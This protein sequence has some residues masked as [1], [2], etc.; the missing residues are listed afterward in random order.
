[1]AKNSLLSG[2]QSEKS[3]PYEPV[4]F[5]SGIG[6][7]GGRLRE[8]TS[9]E[10]LARIEADVFEKGRADGI[11]AGQQVI[12]ETVKRLEAIIGGL[13]DFRNKKIIELMPDIVELAS[14]IAKR[15]IKVSIEKDREIVVSVVRESISKLGGWEEKINVRVNPGDYDI[16]LANLEGLREESRLRDITIEPSASISPGGCYIETQSGEVDARIE[17]QLKEIRDAIATA[18]HS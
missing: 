9:K 10:K 7:Y 17:E 16:I 8:L 13:E 3:K 18:I 11:A 15:I 4:K 5:D 6:G 12:R 14:D 2:K 1:V